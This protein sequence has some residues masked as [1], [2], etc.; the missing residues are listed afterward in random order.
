M[1]SA[2]TEYRKIKVG[3]IVETT[4]QI[5]NKGGDIIGTGVRVRVYKKHK[6][7]GIETTNDKPCATCG[8]GRIVRINQVSVYDVRRLA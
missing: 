4:S 7:L 5:E 6:G 8:I 1:A 2:S 3:D